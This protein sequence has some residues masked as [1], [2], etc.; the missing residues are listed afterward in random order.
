MDDGM[1]LD[2]AHT[3]GAE[4]V[5]KHSERFVAYVGALTADDLGRQVP[6]SAWTVGEVIAHVQSVYERYT[7]DTRRS[8]SPALVAEQNAEDVARLG[9][10]RDAAIASIRAQA[11]L[12]ALTPSMIEPTQQLSFHGGS[13]ITLAG[14]WGNLLGELLAHGDDISA[15]TGE[16]FRIPS[17]DLEIL[18]RYTAPVLGG[19]LSP[20]TAEVDESWDLRYPFG[21]IRFT[22][23]GGTFH[24][25]TDVEPRPI[26]HTIEIDDT[27]EWLLTTPYRRRAP[28]DDHA[29]RLVEM[30]VAL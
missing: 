18:P 3:L 15:A 2:D 27:A 6:S 24:H 19:W 16:Q 13:T 25:G 11:E 14:A 12:M 28:A 7:I 10:D 4:L 9:V 20:A 8:A 30:F 5:R 29:A 21:T 1:T 22:I 17:A 23:T 26:H